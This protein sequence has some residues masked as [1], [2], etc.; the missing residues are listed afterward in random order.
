MCIM[1]ARIVRPP[2]QYDR[3]LAGNS[4]GTKAVLFLALIGFVSGRPAFLDIAIA[5]ILTNFIAT[6]ALMKFLRY[7]SISA[8]IDG[9]AKRRDANG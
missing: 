9:A 5:C 8:A 2:S 7:R 4:L 6:I 3:I 1:A